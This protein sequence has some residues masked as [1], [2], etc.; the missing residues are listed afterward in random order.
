MDPDLATPLL[1]MTAAKTQQSAQ[2]AMLKKQHEMDQ[3][4]FSMIDAAVRS[5]PAPG[6][7]GLKVD[8]TA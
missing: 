1:S 4:L 3:A 7:Q 5:I 6:G 2:V 8:K